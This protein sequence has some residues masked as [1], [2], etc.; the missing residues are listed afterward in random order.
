M[1][2]VV[3]P[4]YKRKRSLLR[5]LDTVLNQSL[6]P[7]EILIV[8]SG[9]NVKELEEIQGRDA[10]IKIIDS[11]PSVCRQRNQG[12]KASS[13]KY[14]L[15]CDDDIELPPN[16]I[17]KLYTYLTENIRVN[18]VTGIE[19]RELMP[20][21]WEE[22][23]I[24]T[25][26]SALLYNYIFGLSI[27]FDLTEMG[28]TGSILQNYLSKRFLKRKNGVSKAGWPQLTSFN[29][30]ILKTS[31]YGLGCS[32]M[33]RDTLIRN[34]FNENLDQ[35]GIGDNYELAIK[36]NGLSEKIHVLQ[37]VGFKHHKDIANRHEDHKSYFLRC[38]SLELFLRK[39][40]VFKFSNRLYYVWSL[41]GN[42][43]RFLF[44]GRFSLFWSN[45]RIL[46]YS[47]INLFKH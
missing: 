8:A 44:R 25:S 30:P 22:V 18:I 10:L 37:E 46:F 41:I 14:V 24:K 34:P 33:E 4:T 15:L 45:Q 17:E 1:V 11:A 27:W 20:G 13:S 16:Y 26:T 23:R 6:S 38:K 3:I 2:S 9:Y 39:L 36:V 12:I 7:H 35:N 21:I 28:R 32:M 5:L 19:L 29:A 31:I 40:P 43:L 47:M 42:G